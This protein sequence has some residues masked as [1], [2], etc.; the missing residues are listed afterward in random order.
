MPDFG[1]CAT[2]LAVTTEEHLA[3]SADIVFED[4]FPKTIP[5]KVS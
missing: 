3:K 2:V 4:F 5:W 1:I